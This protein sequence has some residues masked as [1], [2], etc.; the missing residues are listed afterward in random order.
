MMEEINKLISWF[1]KLRCRFDFHP[2]KECC[3]TS[4]GIQTMYCPICDE[5]WDEH[6]DGAFPRGPVDDTHK[7]GRPSDQRSR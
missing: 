5:H 7:P 2:R 4:K 1:K 6:I 3:G